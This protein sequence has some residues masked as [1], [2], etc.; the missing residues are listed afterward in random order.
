MA[1]VMN[2]YPP[3]C[4][5]RRSGLFVRAAPFAG[6]VPRPPCPSG[7]YP[8]L[9]ETAA[10]EQKVWCSDEKEDAAPNCTIVFNASRGESVR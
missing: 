2:G 8:R 4:G 10:R 9:Y 3:S 6:G 7:T 1:M 5:S